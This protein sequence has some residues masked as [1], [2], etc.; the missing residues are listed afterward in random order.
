[1][2]NEYYILDSTGKEN[3]MPEKYKYRHSYCFY[4][5]SALTVK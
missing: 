2:A 3:K 4:L 5:E 1:M